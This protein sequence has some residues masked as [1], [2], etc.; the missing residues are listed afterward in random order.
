MIA[1]KITF[2]LSILIASALAVPAPDAGA[3]P[4]TKQNGQDAISLNNAFA[5]LTAT[6]ACTDGTNACVNNEFAQCVGGKFLLTACAG[7]TICAALPLVNK[8]GTSITCTTAADR[9]SRIAIT[10]A[11]DAGSSAAAVG[12]GQ[13]AV[14][15]AAAPSAA[16]T[17]VATSSASSAK[18]FLKQNGQDALALN[19]AFTSLSADSTCAAGTNACINS[20]FAQCVGGKFVLT[21]CAGGTICAALPLVNKAG[22]SI[23]CTTAADR[24]ARI[25][26]TGATDAGSSTAAAGLSQGAANA[27]VAPASTPAASS[28]A[29][30]ASASASAPADAKPF[31]LQN[32]KDAQALNLKFASLTADST[33]TDGENACVGTAFAQCV[34]GKFVT[35]PCAATLQCAALPLVN[36][37]GTSITC[38]DLPQALQRIAATGVGSSLTG[39]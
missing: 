24:D 8:P 16:S 1:F 38:T 3:Q 25:A 2:I 6:S 33:C 29:P 22:T 7:G 39:N 37:P 27:V 15:A 17:A 5:T 26:T 20:Q 9:D 19:N 18:P 14:N 4:F 36:S 13:A 11:T 10:G 30:V 34:G 28:A 31:T 12:L 32:G 35:F 21:P 23:T